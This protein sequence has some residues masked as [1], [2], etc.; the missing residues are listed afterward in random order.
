MSK[1]IAFCFLIYDS[2]NQEEIWN[3]FF[4]NI[5]PNKYNIYIHYKINKPLKYFEKYKLK[6]CIP[7][8]YADISLVKAQN[9]LLQEAINDEYNKHM[10]FLSN[11]CIPLKSFK[12]IYFQTKVNI[13]EIDIL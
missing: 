2:I 5:D 9:L 8:K 3:G 11:S 7:T 10:I 4:K 6:N 13:L 1:K 12:F